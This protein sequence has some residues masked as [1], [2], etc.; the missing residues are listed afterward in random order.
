MS[1]I[2]IAAS[3][4]T[5]KDANNAN[6]GDGLLLV[7]DG[8]VAIETSTGVALIFKRSD[9][10]LYQHS[11]ASV[12]CRKLQI[13]LC[14]Y[15]IWFNKTHSAFNNHFG[16]SMQ[17]TG[18]FD[19]EQDEIITIRMSREDARAVSILMHCLCGAEEE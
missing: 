2:L 19:R 8:M 7:D 13:D 9:W 3:H 6:L 14:L 1:H 17:I 10:D 4:I 16:A 5:R 15:P 12:D 11:A 18:R